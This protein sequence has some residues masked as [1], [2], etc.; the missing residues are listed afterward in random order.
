MAVLINIILA[1]ITLY[2]YVVASGRFYRRQEPFLGYLAAA[3]VFDIATALLASF[4][5][6]PTTTLAGVQG[7]PWRSVLF[8]L[9]ITTATLGMFGFIYVLL[10]LLIKG[11]DRPYIGLR[12]FQYRILL[13]AW[14]VG[15]VIALTNSILKMVLKVRLYDYFRF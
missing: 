9:H 1:V 10:V 12:K 2:L 3:V 13:P 6:T 4:K 15:E 7:P 14:A 5:I 11:K 8:L